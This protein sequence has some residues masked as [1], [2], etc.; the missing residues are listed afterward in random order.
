LEVR[1]VPAEFALAQ[2]FPNPFNPETTILYDLASNSE[3]QLEIYNV[4]G[5]LIR[6]LIADQQAAG[7]Y[8]VTWRGD[9][10]TGRSVASGVY[11]YRL[12]TSEFKAVRKLMLLK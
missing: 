1:T 5:Q 2:N 11:F 6:T 8:R 10:A 3:V 7:R 12:H 4:M 9:D